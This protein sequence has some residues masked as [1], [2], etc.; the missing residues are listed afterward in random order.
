MYCRNA[1]PYGA[2]PNP[3]QPGRAGPC[4]AVPPARGF[5]ALPAGLLAAALTLGAADA[6]AQAEKFEEAHLFFELNNTDGDL[7]IHAKVDGDAWRRLKI[8]DLD[9]KV[10]LDVRNKGRLR[11]QGLTEIFFESDEPTFDELPPAQFFRRF[12]E[13]PYVV[14]G[15]TTDGDPLKNRIRLTH[16][17]P[18]PPDPT[19]NGRAK[20]EQCDDEE[21]G[22]DITMVRPP[23]T[24]AWPE[25]TLSH[26]DPDGGGAGV[27]P[28]VAVTI[29]NYE[30][31]VE[32]V[33]DVNGEEFESV[34]SVIL[35][36]DLTAFTIPEEFIAL[37]E[38]FKYE[39]L[40]REKSF[41]QTA[42]ESCFELR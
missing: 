23:V 11:R 36:P 17:M 20:A 39:V 32:V 13:G 25:V 6:R 8:K 21:P 18:A 24:I 16:K 22:F 3:F 19:V 12:P 38:T 37:G 1:K 27:Q 10:I 33:T 40:A 31:V 30:V 29:E 15:R 42:T 34:F 35:P 9:G 14:R 4:A 41:N 2:K 7:G 5:A 28:P 26:P